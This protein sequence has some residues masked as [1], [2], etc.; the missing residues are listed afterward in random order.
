MCICYIWLALNKDEC[1]HKNARGHAYQLSR[2][3]T[4]RPASIHIARNMLAIHGVA[5]KQIE[6]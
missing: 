2:G 5:L 4:A 1:D 6:S 3:T